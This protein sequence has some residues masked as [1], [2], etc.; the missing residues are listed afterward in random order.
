MP[1]LTIA[2]AARLCRRPRSTLQRAIQRGDLPRGTD[3]L[4]ATADLVRAGYL[5]PDHANDPIPPPTA[6]VLRQEAL[7]QVQQRVERLQD[8][9]CEITKCLQ[10]IEALL[11]RIEARM[12]DERPTRHGALQEPH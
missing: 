1:R 6:A 10:R 2:E 5:L 4:I 9:Q 8:N 11:Q 7:A 12:N 3:L